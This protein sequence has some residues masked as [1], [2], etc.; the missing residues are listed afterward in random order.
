[1]MWTKFIWL[2]TGISGVP[3]WTW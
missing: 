1:M 3:L 2:R